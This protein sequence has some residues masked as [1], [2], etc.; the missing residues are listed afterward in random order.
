MDEHKKMFFLKISTHVCSMISLASWMKRAYRNQSAELKND[1]QK[2][3]IEFFR[4]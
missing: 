2:F 4:Y 1:H 3:V